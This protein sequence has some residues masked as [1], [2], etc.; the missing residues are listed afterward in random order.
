[1]LHDARQV[2]QSLF[3]CLSGGGS[4]EDVFDHE[5]SNKAYKRDLREKHGDI[6]W[7]NDDVPIL[8]VNLAEITE[9][10]LANELSL[11]LVKPE[12]TFPHALAQSVVIMD[13]SSHAVDSGGLYAFTS[14]NFTS[15]MFKKTF[16]KRDM[17]LFWGQ[18]R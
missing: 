7:H 12:C 11:Q 16:G 5:L 17:P 13:T 3:L 14:N 8:Q 10:E 9:P 18:L 2:R 6:P 4:G 1:V 15:V